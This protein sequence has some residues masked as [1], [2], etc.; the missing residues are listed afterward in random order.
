MHA[1]LEP[2]RFPLA[3]N[4][5]LAEKNNYFRWKSTPRSLRASWIPRVAGNLCFPLH[6]SGGGFGVCAK[7]RRQDLLEVSWRIQMSIKLLVN[8][9]VQ[10]RTGRT[11][12]TRK[13]LIQGN[14]N[15]AK[16]RQQQAYNT[17]HGPPTRSLRVSLP[18]DQP[19]L[20][21]MSWLT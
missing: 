10:P 11:R 13:C 7:L 9:Q 19:S 4:L 8:L 14:P 6:D 2:A 18:T 5:G 12:R 15:C 17:P 20:S 21:L 3:P 16:K 1:L